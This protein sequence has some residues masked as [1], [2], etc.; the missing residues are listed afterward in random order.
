[1]ELRIPFD[2]PPTRPGY[3]VRS[4]G[5]QAHRIARNEW[6]WFRFGDNDG[7][8]DEDR[9]PGWGAAREVVEGLLR[10]TNKG[11]LTL[12]EVAELPWVK[13]GINVAGGIKRGYEDDEGGST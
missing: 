5:K 8:W 6:A 11:R 12:D 9:V 10:K 13:A 1:M 4:R 7:E 3:R 2:P